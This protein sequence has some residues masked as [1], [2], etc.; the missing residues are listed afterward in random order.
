MG[1]N[2]RKRENANEWRGH[3]KNLLWNDGKRK[4]RVFRAFLTLWCSFMELKLTCKSLS[5]P[6]LLILENDMFHKLILLLL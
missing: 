1:E 4:S 6:T 5:S 3:P 2:A